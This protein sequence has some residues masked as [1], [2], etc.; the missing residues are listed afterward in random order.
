MIAIF[1]IKN[2]ESRAQSIQFIGRLH[3]QIT[4][5]LQRLWISERLP[6]GWRII[7]IAFFKIWQSFLFTSNSLELSSYDRQR[8]SE[9][10]EKSLDFSDAMTR[11]LFL[12]SLYQLLPPSFVCY[13]S[14]RSRHTSKDKNYIFFCAKLSIFHFIFR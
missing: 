4:I 11:E 12:V 2:Y 7:E 9:N 14:Q 3:I 5:C 13:C 6:L 10:C 1:L 8:A